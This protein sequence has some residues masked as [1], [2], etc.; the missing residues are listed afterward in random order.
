MC[1][2]GMINMN[3]TL[4]L[5]PHNET[6]HSENIEI[7][8]EKYH[9]LLIKRTDNKFQFYQ[10]INVDKSIY[11]EVE[12]EMHKNDIQVGE[13][14][15]NNNIFCLF[16][17]PN[18]L[19]KTLRHFTNY[20]LFEFPD[21]EFVKLTALMVDYG[22]LIENIEFLGENYFDEELLQKIE[23]I[24]FRKNPQLLIELINDNNLKINKLKMKN[25]NVYIDF[26]V[27]GMIYT[28][29]EFKSLLKCIRFFLKE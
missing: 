17:A 21:E 9:C 6:P 12:N 16:E 23:N 8:N 10:L 7:G 24:L 2:Y 11:N 15:S 25:N 5:N 26:Y 29:V 28:N 14:S 27:S 19:S 13:I 1:V 18:K 4:L 22:L 3:G 20:R